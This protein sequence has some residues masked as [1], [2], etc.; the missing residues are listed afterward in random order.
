MTAPTLAEFDHAAFVN[1]LNWNTNVLRGHV[2]QHHVSR[3]LGE[4]LDHSAVWDDSDI[5][6]T[7]GITIEV[8]SAGLRQTWTTPHGDPAITP[9]SRVRFTG[10]R[11]RRSAP[12]GA[13]YTGE[14]VF[15]S[16]VYVFGL[17]T[18]ISDAFDC[19][20]ATTW[21]WWVMPRAALAARGYDSI[22]LPVVERI[23]TRATWDEMPAVVT[24]C[25]ERAEQ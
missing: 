7:R 18:D 13:T 14:P 6:T 11:R 2:A 10:L 17:H 23:A 19:R 21:E 3:A 1:S 12:G 15:R 22:S 8:K 16:Q 25:A 5:T 24:T 4:A 20:D 9:R